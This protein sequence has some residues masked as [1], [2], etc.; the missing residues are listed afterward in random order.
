MRSKATAPSKSRRANRFAK[1]RRRPKVPVNKSATLAARAAVWTDEQ[2]A[3]FEA[4]NEHVEKDGV[5]SYG[6][7]SF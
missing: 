5:F 7:R 3:A 4:Y 6:L 1:Y 2:L